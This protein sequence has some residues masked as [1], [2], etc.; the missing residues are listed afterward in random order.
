[1]N[2]IVQLWLQLFRRLSVVAVIAQ[3]GRIAAAYCAVRAWQGAHGMLVAAATLFGMSSWIWHIGQGHLL[4]VLCVPESFLMPQFKR[5]LLEFGGIDGLVWVLAP[6]LVAAALQVP[7]L[8][9]VAC[10]LLLLATVGLTMGAH[11]S[12]GLYVWPLFVLFGWK[13]RFFLDL[14]E[15]ALPSPL[16]PLLLIAVAALLL[17]LSIRP[18]LRIEDREPDTS[19]LGSTSVGRGA[20][21]S[22][23]GETRRMG[24]FT[25]RVNA[26]FDNVAQRAM[27]RALTLYTQHPTFARR[28]VLVRRLLLPHDNPQAIALR[29]ALAAVIFG[30]YFFVVMHRPNFSPVLIG[31]YAIMASV[32]RFPQ[33]NAGMV[34]MR[35]N[36]A[37]LYLTLAPATRAEY[38]KTISDALIVL[39]PISILTALT[40]TALGAV[41]VRAS[42]PWHMLFV[43][44]IVSASASLAGLA[45]HL[46]GPEGTTGRAVANAVLI[47]GVMA[48]YWGGYWLVGVAGY[49][50]GGGV[51]ALITLGFSFG[52]WFAAQREYQLRPPRFD[53]PIA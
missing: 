46:V 10:G 11:R 8:L 43:A 40:Y 50:I 25:R 52:A 22:I 42:D 38:Q 6:T 20:A 32:S 37:D 14:I 15:Q 5:R 7:H 48:V 47:L 26:L 4:R 1:M 2:A 51:L 36:M 18:L 41:L 30:F 16:T 39:V 49:A 13:P 31:G 24:V 19:P 23:P 53:A 34:R 28:M 3:L 44:A 35:P 29:I 9:L 27:E 17:N 21:R 12:A 33:L 45:V